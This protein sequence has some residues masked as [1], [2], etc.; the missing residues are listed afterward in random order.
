MR[1]VIFLFLMLTQLYSESLGSLDGDFNE[2]SKEEEFISYIQNREYEKIN[3]F[4]TNNEDID[5]DVENKNT[6]LFYAID[7]GDIKI[8]KLLIE[9][10]ANIYGLNSDLE[11]PL[12]IAVQ[13]NHVEIV[14]LLLENSCSVSSE[15]IYGNKPIFYAKEHAYNEII[16]LLTVYEKNREEKVDS[17]EEFIKNF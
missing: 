1:V 12:H 11:T 2:R 4:I 15:D 17:L 8:V 13:G 10:E 5:F 14:R 9:H 3:R 7:V 16:E 6:P